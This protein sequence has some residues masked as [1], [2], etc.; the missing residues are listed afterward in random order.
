MALLSHLLGIA[1]DGVFVAAHWHPLTRSEAER[2]NP[3][4]TRQLP[5]DA[6]LYRCDEVADDGRCLVHDTRPQV[7]RGYPWYGQPPRLM[8][9]PDG[10]CGYAVD[11]P[12]ARAPAAPP[13]AIREP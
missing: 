5:V 6:Y 1:S 8:P 4:Y 12:T 7:C 9:L 13:A 2:S 3:F 11:Q 10:H